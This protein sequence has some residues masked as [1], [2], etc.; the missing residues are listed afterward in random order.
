M[1]MNVILQKEY[2]SD[3]F[4]NEL[5]IYKLKFVKKKFRIILS[6]DVG[7][8]VNQFDA[9]KDS[10]KPLFDIYDIS[11]N[12]E[13]I[14]NEKERKKKGKKTGKRKKGGKGEITKKGKVQK[15][16]RS[17]SFLQLSGQKSGTKKSNMFEENREDAFRKFVE[18]EMNNRGIN[19]D[20]EN[21]QDVFSKLIKEKSKNE[22]MINNDEGKELI[23]HNNHSRDEIQKNVNSEDE[24]N[25]V[26]DEA[27]KGKGTKIRQP[28][29]MRKG[30]KQKGVD[31]APNKMQHTRN[32]ILTSGAKPE[33]G[34]AGEAGGGQGE[35]GQAQEE[36]EEEEEEGE[37]DDEDEEDNE[38]EGQK[39][40]KG[41]DDQLDD[42]DEDIITRDFGHYSIVTNS[43]D[44]LDDIAVDAS[45][46]SKLSI[47]S[48][49]IPYNEAN[50]TS[51][52]HQRH[53][54]LN[55]IGNK[56]YRVVL[57]TKNPKFVE[58]EEADEGHEASFVEK[59]E[60][61]GR[62]NGP[63][64]GT[65][66]RAETI[67]EKRGVDRKS[68]HLYDGVGTLDFRKA[69]KKKRAE[70]K[71][72]HVSSKGGGG[73]K[74]EEAQGDDRIDRGIMGKLK[75]MLKFLSLN[76]NHD[77]DRI[78][79]AESTDKGGNKSDD[80]DVN[81]SGSGNRRK[82]NDMDSILSVDQLVDQYLLNLKND[83]ISQQELIFVLRGDL[84]LHSPFMRKVIRRGN[85]K[86]EKYIKKHF[87]EV[88]KISYDVSSPINFLCFFVPTVFNM[89]NFNLL[90]EALEI[91][92]NELKR[93]TENWS[94][95]NTY[96]TL[97]GDLW[98]GKQQR[99]LHRHRSDAG[100][101]DP[102]VGE[103]EHTNFGEEGG[104]LHRQYVK[105]RK[106]LYNVKYSFLRKMWG[107][108]P[109]LSFA[110]KMNKRNVNVEKE[111]LNFLPKELR[112][113]STWNLSVMRVFNA[114]FLAGYGNKN[115]KVCV[116]DSGVDKNHIDLMKNV[117]I[118]EYSDKY[119]MTEDF[120]DFMVKNPTDSS[121]H[122]THVTGIIGGIANDL[123]MVGV[124]PNVT[125]ISLRFIDGLKYGGSFHAI[126]AINV[127][128]LNKTPIINA[129][130]GSSKYDANI[131]MAVQRLKYT[132]NGKGTVLISAAGNE[133]K[134]NDVHPLYPASFKL[135]HVYSVA[136]ISRNLE[137]SP[138][139]N[140]GMKSVHI[141]APGHHIYSTTPNNSYK[142]NTGTSMAAPHVCG[143]NALIYS[144][145]YNQGFIPQA[146]E[147][148]E[149]LTR[150]SIKVVSRKR[151]TINDSLVNA[152]AAV[153]TTLLGGL[154]M[155]MDCHFV[156]F[157]LDKG[158]K[159]H[160]PVVFSAY[161]NGVYETD[162]VIAV[163]PTEEN[164]KVYGEILIPIRIVTNVKAENF[165]E[166]PRIG[167]KMIIDDNEASH[168]EVLSYICENA[169]Y[170]LYELDSY[171]LV[172]SLVLFFVAFL[173]IVV[174][175]IIY[176]KRKLHNKYCTN[177]NHAHNI[178]RNTVVGQKHILDNSANEIL[179][180]EKLEYLEKLR[181]SVRFSITKSKDELNPV[182]KQKCSK[183]LNFENYNELIKRPLLKR[184][185]T[186]I[187][188][189][190]NVDRSIE[191]L[192]DM[193][194]E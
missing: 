193:Y 75:G 35:E 168:D 13:K 52:T 25:T 164:S 118:P 26:Q 159:K 173:L 114:W 51:F 33:Q 188:S 107:M 122:G 194:M 102:Q 71:E 94:F 92:F 39:G 40:K 175:T 70:T 57:M 68:A 37:E 12:F 80:G 15:G 77:E 142:I 28:R 62:E 23:D 30:E 156:K 191:E 108:E 106:N 138:F 43:K 124:A 69:Y 143:V 11:A 53:I 179:A 59:G 181:N 165:K 84:D 162:I 2:R 131:Y 112:E 172:I 169:L 154:W 126:K 45:D 27:E 161:K 182:I 98:Q 174:T 184:G 157:H 103:A 14:K 1:L 88:E 22:D 137:I 180:K 41:E 120:F 132:F 34:E 79:L 24:E 48:I 147:V 135:P 82:R 117:H 100:D 150:T 21:E 19:P 64:S 54:V 47:E 104:G 16:E 58:V 155:Q 133:N 144:V 63:K 151:K 163:I 140:Y 4:L 5:E 127:C 158:K 187:S 110:K 185:D 192:D 97:D 44:L 46:I 116:I 7:N 134:N 36:E 10:Y 6:S 95:S 160:I 148:L 42:E 3:N 18:G 153:L 145:C 99:H 76:S 141:L 8:K 93:Y 83:N 190:N 86:F 67:A 183:K 178:K 189:G 20:K 32:N 128:I 56:K 73:D 17:E 55:N 87:K 111:I 115:V 78:K 167:K 31:A 119:E 109:I 50:R 129:S 105:K 89:N 60:E 152:E 9:L 149:I 65:E 166:S 139:S 72:S 136:S 130:W 90:K 186:K 85:A 121:G 81:G 61:N 177:E 91:L 96:V 123:G 171:F 170:N 146:E 101:E 74:G 113:Y 38:E 49:N 125:L 176:I 29:N 66:K